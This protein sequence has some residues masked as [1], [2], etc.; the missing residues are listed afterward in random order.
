MARVITIVAVVLVAVVFV[1]LV[2][3]G[4]AYAMKSRPEKAAPTLPDTL[5]EVTVV[6]SELV[7]LEVPL[8]QVDTPDNDAKRVVS[9][10]A[11]CP[12]SVTIGYKFTH[13]NDYRTYDLVAP[14]ELVDE[15]KDAQEWR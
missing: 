1:G 7:G 15:I 2:G 12:D 5:P 3:G 10:R 14:E 8:D 9:H 13:V 6:A 4:A 11:S